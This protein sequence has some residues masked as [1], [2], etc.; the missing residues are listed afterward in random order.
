MDTVRDWWKNRLAEDIYATLR[1]KEKHQ[2][3]Y[4]GISTQLWMR[5]NLVNWILMLTQRLD[6]SATTLHL[7][8]YLLDNFMDGLTVDFNKLFLVAETCFILAVKF[9]DNSR[10]TLKFSTVM[11]LFPHPAGF[12]PPGSSVSPTHPSY[13]LQDYKSMERTVLHFFDWK[14]AVS[15]MPHF[16]PY[17]LQVALDDDD[18]QNGLP[19]LSKPLVKSHVERQTLYFQTV[20]LQDPSFCEIAPSLLAASCVA[21]SRMNLELTPTWPKRLEL[22]T[23][24]RLEELMPC[25][26]KLLKFYRFHQRFCNGTLPV[27]IPNDIILHPAFPR[28]IPHPALPRLIPHPAFPQSYIPNDENHAAGY[29]TS[30]RNYDRSSLFSA[31]PNIPWSQRS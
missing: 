31:A 28:L 24:Y 3:M 22:I 9:E 14:L 17:F 19:I 10:G 8:V 26:Q 29:S 25:T 1:I 15:V 6:A 5:P 13:T 4:L 20:C 27:A 12:I 7:A 18:L 30:L 16:V 11:N 23:D 2:D 21:S